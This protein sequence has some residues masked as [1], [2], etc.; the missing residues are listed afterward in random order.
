MTYI[1][2]G[3]GVDIRVDNTIVFGLSETIEDF[4][5]EGGRSM[6]GGDVETEGKT[7]LSFF[8]HKGALGML[9]LFG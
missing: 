7:G 1:C 5:Q 4:L 6:R 3:V 2:A 8:F 9:F